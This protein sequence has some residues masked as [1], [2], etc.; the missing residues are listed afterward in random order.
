MR[1]CNRLL[2]YFGFML[3]LS[4]IIIF[5]LFV[6]GT[7][8]QMEDE[9][10]AKR[11][12]NNFY[13]KPDHVVNQVLLIGEYGLSSLNSYNL[14]SAVKFSPTQN[15]EFYY[16]FIRVDTETGNPGLFKHQ[17][18]FVFIG[19]VSTDFKTFD[20][21]YSEYGTDAWRFG[22]GLNDGFG[23]M[24]NG[25]P[26]LFLSHST[27]F[28]F[29]RIDF[30]NF[31]QGEADR[32]IFRQFNHEF[33]FGQI[34]SGG[35][36]YKIHSIF[37]VNAQYEISQYYGNYQ[38]LPWFGMWLIDN[39][40]QRWIDYFEPDLIK[41]MD[42]NYPWV[43]FVYKNFIS[44]LSYQLRKHEMY[45]PFDSEAPLYYDAFKIGITLII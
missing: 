13:S 37:H 28:S 41:V 20:V 32:K 39:V 5:C 43:K 11:F 29:S 7:N 14:T 1:Y 2:A 30:Y 16:G 33:K 36:K 24:V 22:F 8:A 42:N 17:S 38:F 10:R 3:K 12:I 15:L 4:L 25:E 18:E 27:A 40:L 19:N 23:F 6:Y 21:D 44:L 31:P 26:T 35:I 45:F 34:Y 9:S